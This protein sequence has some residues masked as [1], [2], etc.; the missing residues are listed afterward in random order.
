MS[1]YTITPASPAPHQTAA[2]ASLTS[3][4]DEALLKRKRSGRINPPQPLDFPSDPAE[5][6]VPG[7]DGAPVARAIRDCVQ[8]LEPSFLSLVDDS[9]AHQGHSGAAGYSGESHFI[10]HIVSDKFDG[11]SRVKRHQAVFSALGDLMTTKIHA[12]NIKAQTHAE[13]DSE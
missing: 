5:L 8:A 13:Y 12:L 2:A 1:K 4:Q 3:P 7:E 10:M 6:S 9:A 11:M